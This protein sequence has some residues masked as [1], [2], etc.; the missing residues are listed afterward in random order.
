MP[1]GPALPR[2]PCD[3]RDLRENTKAN[4]TSPLL[5]REKRHCLPER[6]TACCGEGEVFTRQPCDHEFAWYSTVGLYTCK[7]TPGGAGT[8][9]RAHTSTRKTQ[10]NLTTIQ[11][12]ANTPARPRDDCIHVPV[13]VKRHRGEPGHIHGT[14][15]RT[16][17]HGSHRRTSKPSKPTN[18]PAPVLYCRK[19]LSSHGNLGRSRPS[20]LNAPRFTTVQYLT[21]RKNAAAISPDGRARHGGLDEDTRK[22][23][24]NKMRL[25]PYKARASYM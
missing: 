3:L 1:L 23:S 18:T 16:R 6:Q 19:F 7:K 24:D 22:T 15:G 13:P 10:T 17:A 5:H 20:F 25:S 8:V 4:L 11:T 2:R 21:S 9:T 14:H 12:R